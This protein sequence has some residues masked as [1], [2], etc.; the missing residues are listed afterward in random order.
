MLKKK[1]RKFYLDWILN[2]Q[3]AIGPSPNKMEDLEELKSSNIKSILSLCSEEEASN[4]KEMFETF[5]VRRVLL[6]DHKSGRVPTIKEI[7]KA[8]N[9]LEELIKDHNPVFI[10]CFAAMERSPLI[11]IAWLAKEHKLSIKEA[12]DYVMQAHQ[13]TNPLS[14][15]LEV[16]KYLV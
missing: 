16:L 9:A 11:C 13:G 14:E 3:L 4:P 5:Q 12:L 8:L 6:P 1:K 15:Q 10:H 2:N 7:N